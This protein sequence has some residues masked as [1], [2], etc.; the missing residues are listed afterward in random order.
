MTNATRAR[1]TRETTHPSGSRTMRNLRTPISSAILV[2]GIASA[3]VAYANYCAPYTD[4][5]TPSDD[6]SCT[7]LCCQQHQ[8]C[9]VTSGCQMAVDF[10]SGVSDACAV[11]NTQFLT[12]LGTCPFGVY[13]STVPAGCEADCTANLC[14]GPDGCGGFCTEVAY[15]GLLSRRPEFTAVLL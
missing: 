14:G 6:V 13:E 8:E 12:C 4:L 1:A 7:P 2:G 11:C 5:V 15:C 10:P 9:Y 3:G